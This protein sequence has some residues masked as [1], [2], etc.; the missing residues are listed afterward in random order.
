MERSENK[1]SMITVLGLLLISTTINSFVMLQL[2]NWLLKPVGLPEINIGT[3]FGLILFVGFL[4]P[5]RLGKISEETYKKINNGY[6]IYE[7][8]AKALIYLFLGWL[9][10]MFI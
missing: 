3:A 9:T 4:T 5:N 2:W 8:L 7:I 6:V 10:N 1:I